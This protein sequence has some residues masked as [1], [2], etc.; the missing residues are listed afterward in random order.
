MKKEKNSFS[1]GLIYGI[2]PHI[3][4]I[5]FV[6]FS[7]I[8]ATT[9]SVFLRPF[10]LNKY[11]FYIL[12]VISFLAATVSAGFYL[13]RNGILSLIGIKRKWRYLIILYGT[14]IA[15][16][17][18]FFLVIFPA[19]ANLSLKSKNNIQGLTNNQ[20]LVNLQVN[21]PCSG[22][23]SLISD[24]LKKVAGVNEVIFKLPNLFTVYYN[25]QI[26]NP[27]QILKKP[28]FLDYPTKVIK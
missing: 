1:Q 12:I 16:N 10:L 24:E 14:T 13:K 8:G 6:I 20:S 28:I 4:C 11:F 23:A 18:L 25:P 2:I 9:A 19:T 7:I 3:F 26:T 17:L 27:E 21:I 22:H 5:L 15:I